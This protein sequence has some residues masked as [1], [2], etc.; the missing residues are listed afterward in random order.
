MSAFAGTG[1]KMTPVGLAGRAVV[2]CDASHCAPLG[3]VQKS[4]PQTREDTKMLQ[5][6]LLALAPVVTF[7][8]VGEASA[9]LAQMKARRAAGKDQAPEF[10][11]GDPCNFFEW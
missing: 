5:L 3:A 9:I 1:S 11:P 7:A 6:A 4:D 8:L 2:L 10:S